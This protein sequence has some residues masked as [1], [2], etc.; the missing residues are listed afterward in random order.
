MIARLAALMPMQIAQLLAGFGAIWAFTRLMTPA[1]YGLYALIFSAAMLAHTFALTWAEAAAFRFHIA[2]RATGRLAD[3]I[4]TLLAIATFAAFGVA[5]VVWAIVA[6]ANLANGAALIAFAGASTFFRF[7]TRIAREGERAEGRMW[8]VSLYESAYLLSGFALG[9]LLLKITALGAAAPFA[10]MLAA[11]FLIA[12]F[13]APNLMRL[14]EGGAATFSRARNYALY[15]WPLAL[16]LALDLGLQTAARGI[17]AAESGAPAVGA[18]AAAFGLARLVEIVF[19]WGGAALGPALLHAYEARGPRGAREAAADGAGVLAA[20][21]I[22]AAIG[23]ALVAEPLCALM[24]GEGLRAEAARLLPW[25]ALA[26][27]ATGWSVHYWSEAFQ[28][29]RRSFVRAAIMAA[30]AA[31]FLIAAPFVIARFGAEGASVLAALCAVLSAGLLAYIGRRFVTL[32]LPWRDAGKSLVAAAF[33]TTGVLA[34]PALAPALE[35]F[36]KAAF[37]ACLYAI[38]AYVL[39]VAGIRTRHAGAPLAEAAP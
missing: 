20:L 13:D 22:P 15:G 16:A 39:D 34:V 37:G 18:F 17:I 38:A 21:T 8:R 27:F 35:L 14:A 19:L 7:F 32:P 5:L 4:A 29:A 12:A 6:S 26:A 2:A 30:P 24:V 31:L 3:H 23:L 9:A 10:G 33:M 28:L 25:F 11:G 36:A 1:E